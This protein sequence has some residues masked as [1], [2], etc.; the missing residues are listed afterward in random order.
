MSRVGSE[1]LR[2]GMPTFSNQICYLKGE[3]QT[4]QSRVESV[5]HVFVA[6]ETPIFA[7]GFE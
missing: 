5:R 7:N 2:S 4:P 6:G 1:W 3:G